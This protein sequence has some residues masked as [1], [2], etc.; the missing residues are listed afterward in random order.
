M[1]KIINVNDK[2]LIERRKENRW[3]G[4]GV[5]LLRRIDARESAS[6]KVAWVLL[7]WT[8]RGCLDVNRKKCRPTKL[9]ISGKYDR[10]LCGGLKVMRV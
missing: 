1:G 5:D 4:L 10:K 9:E 6:R 2:I 7:F 3:G 8:T